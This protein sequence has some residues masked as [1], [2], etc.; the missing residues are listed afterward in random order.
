MSPP[1]IRRLTPD[2]A[3]A[4]F[5]L[6]RLDD[7]SLTADGWR[8]VVGRAPEAG[9]VLGA[10]AD[11][12]VQGVLRYSILAAAQDGPL[13]NIEALTAFDLFDPAPVADALV[14]AALAH[15]LRDHGCARIGLSTGVETVRRGPVLRSIT[16]AA[17]LHR[18]F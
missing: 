16:E 5:A 15:A 17:S 9:G 6:A 11:D 13:F 2:D 7:P 18:V 4:T 3:D 10:L 12:G 8:A 1:S 14:Q